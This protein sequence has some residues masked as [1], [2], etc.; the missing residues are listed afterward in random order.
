NEQIDHLLVSGKL[1]ADAQFDNVHLNTNLPYG[2]GPSDHDAVLSRV[3][4]NH[5]P[6]AT[7]NAYGTDEDVTLAVDAAHGVLANDSDVNGDALAASLVAGPAHGTLKLNADGSF[8]YLADA[9]YNGA[10]SF[11]Y[12]AKDAFGGTSGVAQVQLTVAAVNDAPVAK[13]DAASVLEDGSVDIVV[14]A[15]DSDVELDVLSIVL[16]DSHS[17]LGSSLSIVDGKVHY[18]ADADAFDLLAAGQSVTDSFTYS[19]DDGH[20][21][22]S[23]PVTVTVTVRE[24]GD[25]QSLQ[26]SNKSGTWID[27]AG[28]DTSYAGGNGE[29]IL[30]GMD[31]ADTLDGGNGKDVLVGGAGIDTLIGGNGA[32]T[33]VI[34]ADSGRDIVVDFK[35]NLDRILVGYSGGDVT[36]WIKGA[37]SGTGFAFA[38]V[39]TD[40]NGQVD[41]VAISGGSLGA[42]SIVLSDWTIAALVGQRFLSE[43]LKVLGDWLV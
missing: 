17:A 9:N 28:R 12:V 18:V 4:V 22:R 24:A 32:D 29:D 23:A 7:A 27:A 33:F 31:G 43:D 41:A 19:A 25:N 2:S 1:A 35:P 37:H 39:D 40:G 42:N 26:G 13:A 3:L 14:L 6:A 16:G 34:S 20:G 8:T 15:N 10:D 21:G 30:F 11:S 38:D 5:G 36:A